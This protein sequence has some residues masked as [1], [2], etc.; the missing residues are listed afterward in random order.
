MKDL[1]FLKK[2]T[3][4]EPV[5]TTRS[6]GGSTLV[7]LPVEG[8]HLRVFKNGRVYP[9]EKL[10]E[11][12]GL[13]YLPK[14]EII[15]PEGN[16]EVSVVGNGLDIFSSD[17]W[18]QVQGLEE[19]ILFVAAIKRQEKPGKLAPK[20]DLFGSCQYKEG[21]PA[22]DIY[23]QG[24]STFGKTRLVHMLADVYGVN[25]D[26]S[27]FVDVVISFENEMPKTIEN[28][29]QL[30]KLIQ[31]GDNQGKAE[32]I[33]RENLNIYPIF[34]LEAPE[35]VEAPV[36]EEAKEQTKDPLFETDEQAPAT[37][38]VKEEVE[39]D[40][41]GSGANILGDITKEEAPVK[42]ADATKPDAPKSNSIL[43]S[44]I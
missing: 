21:L 34:V 35:V 6:G 42:E 10:A 40:N 3:V 11:D 14:Q 9:S 28:V 39:F 25:W 44:L 4:A 12:F 22:T 36:K 18:K 24:P 27:K 17:D 15:D 20:M 43:E 13:H 38:A 16:M 41:A 33:R 30:P 26:E 32:Y 8:A 5:A 2:A 19:R 31:R 23:T 29:Y 7:K 1:S 37:E